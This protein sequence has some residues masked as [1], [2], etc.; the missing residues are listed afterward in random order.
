M[1]NG[2]YCNRPKKTEHHGH[3]HYHRGSCRAGENRKRQSSGI[4]LNPDYHQTSSSDNNRPEKRYDRRES[5]LYR[6]TKECLNRAVGLDPRH[7]LE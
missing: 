5:E 7:S 1:S 4:D 2:H 6:S 3:R